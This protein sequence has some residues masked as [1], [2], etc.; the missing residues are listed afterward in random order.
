[1]STPA[2]AEYLVLRLEAPLQAWGGV[3]RAPLRP[4]RANP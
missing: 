3:A 1:M 4:T 2:A